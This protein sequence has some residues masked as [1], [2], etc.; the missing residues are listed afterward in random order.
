MRE[1]RL[2]VRRID[3]FGNYLYI[4]LTCLF[5]KHLKCIKAIVLDEEDHNAQIVD[6]LCV[7][8]PLVQR[9]DLGDEILE[10]Q[11]HRHIVRVNDKRLVATLTNV[12]FAGSLL[13]R[14]ADLLD[15]L[16]DDD[17]LMAPDP[18]SFLD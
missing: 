7:L 5:L 11:L 13:D 14:V 8:K 18:H 6:C 2:D 15:D 16:I 4:C 10:L 9:L 1:N 17:D 12:L 3:R